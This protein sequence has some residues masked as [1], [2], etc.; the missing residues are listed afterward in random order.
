MKPIQGL[1]SKFITMCRGNIY[2]QKI[3]PKLL[4]SRGPN[5]SITNC[6]RK[7]QIL[8]VEEVEKMMRWR[9]RVVQ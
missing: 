8:E 4:S 5:N 7:G 2:P 9:C 1:E 3:H 6:T